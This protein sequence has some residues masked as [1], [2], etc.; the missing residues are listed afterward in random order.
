MHEIATR[1]GD[2]HFEFADIEGFDLPLLD[3][4]VPPSLGQYNQLH[5]KASTCSTR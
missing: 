4:P 1:R 3:Q 5:T 2:A